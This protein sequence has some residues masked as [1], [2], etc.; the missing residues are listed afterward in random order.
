MNTISKWVLGGVIVVAVVW[1]G[2][3]FPKGN[4]VIQQ[5]V[6]GAAGPTVYDHQYFLGGI[7]VGGTIATSSTA[8]A[9]TTSEKDFAQRPTYIVWTPNVVPT[10]T[11]TATSTFP[12]IPNVGDVATVLIKNA[13]TTTGA[14]TWAAGSGLSITKSEDDAA[15]TTAHGAFARF[16]FIRT[17]TLTVTAIQENLLSP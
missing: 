6:G 3:T 14:I 2:V 16:T 5:I 7:T 1:L 9:Y 11:I 15:N 4:P 10:I 12:L 8:A 17:S 13:T